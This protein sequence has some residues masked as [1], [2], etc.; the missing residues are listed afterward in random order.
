MNNPVLTYYSL[1][2][3]VTAF[4]STRHGGCSKGPYGE[5]NINHYC[6]DDDAS[7]EYNRAALCSVLGIDD[8][9]LIMPHQTHGTEIR[10]I[11]AGFLA[12]PS[13]GRQPLLEG[14]DALMTDVPGVCIGVSTADCIPI[15]IYDTRQKACCAV[16]AGW[17]GTVKKIAQ[18]AVNAMIEVYGCRPSDLKCCIGPG[19]SLDSFEVGE[20]VYEAFAGAGF[21]MN[22]ISWRKDKWHIDLWKCNAMQ[23]ENAGVNPD[24]IHI[25]G[26]CTYSNCNDYFSARRL[27]TA[28]GRIF[29]GI[30]LKGF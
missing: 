9:R 24:A 13:V 5:F 22:M 20:E 27:G 25:S 18:K 6:G 23:L 26:I 2:P 28:S 12:L 29:T 3:E 16:H 8:G 4:S 17:R 30:I 15:I 11:S 14:V 1:S 21:D 7:V 19:I 10:R